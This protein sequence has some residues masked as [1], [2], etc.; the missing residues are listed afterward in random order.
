V[1][2]NVCMY[3]TVNSIF[4][5]SLTVLARVCCI[6]LNASKPRCS[7]ALHEKNKANQILRRPK[8]NHD[9]VT[10]VTVFRRPRSTADYV[11]IFLFNYLEILRLA[12][13][14]YPTFRAFST[15][16]LR[17]IFLSDTFFRE[18]GQKRSCVLM[19]SRR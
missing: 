4:H 10:V 16:F 11:L 9:S 17:N 5:I 3:S 2:F 12:E 15:L 8:I 13:N 6:Y 1:S 7:R 14:V 18:M 19:Q